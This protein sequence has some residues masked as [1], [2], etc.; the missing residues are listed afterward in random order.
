MAAI[1][2]PKR[3]LSPCQ[4]VNPSVDR[5]TSGRIAHRGLVTALGEQRHLPAA[6]PGHALGV[7][8][9]FEV[10]RPVGLQ[11]DEA[12]LPRQIR[13]QANDRAGQWKEYAE[14]VVLSGEEHASRCPGPALTLPQ[15]YSRTALSETQTLYLE[16]TVP[17]YLTAWPSRDLIRAGHQQ[18]TKEW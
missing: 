15:R 14:R 18:I 4:D 8:L 9:P 7:A 13:V 17:S 10:L 5:V 11:E 6:I 1:G 16:T 3:S 12:A 2:D